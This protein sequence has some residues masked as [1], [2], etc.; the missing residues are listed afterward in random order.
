MLLLV[1]KFQW[2]HLW[3]YWM[4]LNDVRRV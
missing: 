2:P 1:Y 4:A 3:H